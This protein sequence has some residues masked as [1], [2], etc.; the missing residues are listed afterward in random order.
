MRLLH[1]N[2]LLSHSGHG[3]YAKSITQDVHEG[4]QNSLKWPA[5]PL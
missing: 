1:K 4:F 3:K 5:V 2:N